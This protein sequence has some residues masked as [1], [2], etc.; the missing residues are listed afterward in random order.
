MK[1]NEEVAVAVVQK[2][3]YMFDFLTDS[4]VVN[5]VSLLTILGLSYG[6][7]LLALLRF[8]G[9]KRKARKYDKENAKLIRRA[10]LIKQFELGDDSE[11]AETV[12]GI[13]RIAIERAMKEAVKGSDGF[14]KQESNDYTEN[15]TV[16]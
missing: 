2:Q 7:A 12:K 1:R 13:E 15:P 4:V 3:K 10:W 11:F 16:G 6:G 8:E 9:I 14:D 5:V